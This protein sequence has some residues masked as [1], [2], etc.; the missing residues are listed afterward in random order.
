M[1]PD[2]K[3]VY[4]PRFVGTRNRHANLKSDCSSLQLRKSIVELTLALVGQSATRRCRFD[5][6]NL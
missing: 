5:A 4:L 2:K 3:N 6:C 1:F